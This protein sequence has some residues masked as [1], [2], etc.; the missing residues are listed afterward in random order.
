MQTFTR[1][2]R[3]G[4]VFFKM[5]AEAS[6]EIVEISIA[7][8]AATPV[9]LG[10]LAVVEVFGGD[11]VDGLVELYY[12]LLGGVVFVVSAVEMSSKNASCCGSVVCGSAWSKSV[13]VR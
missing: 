8:F 10:E 2:G 11:V 6:V 3:F 9:I 4:V 13:S 5:D 12:G 7:E 1:D